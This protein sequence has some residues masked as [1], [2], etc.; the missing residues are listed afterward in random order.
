MWLT[1]DH[2]RLTTVAIALCVSACATAE[3]EMKPGANMPPSLQELKQSSYRGILPDP[4]RLTNGDYEGAPYDEGGAARPMVQ[5]IE[6]V[7]LNGDLDGDGHEEAAVV[8]VEQSSGSG[9]RLYLAIAGRDADGATTNLATMLIGDRVQIISASIN[10]GGVDMRLVRTGPEDACCCPGEIVS[11]RWTMAGGSL[12]LVRDKIEGRLNAAELA[13]SSWRLQSMAR[14]GVNREDSGITVKFED[15]RVSGRSGCNN[16]FGGIE[17]GAGPGELRIG[18]LAGTRMACAPPIMELE[19]TY[20]QAL[21]TSTRFSFLAGT[22]VLSSVDADGQITQLRFV[23]Q[24][25]DAPD[26]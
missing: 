8:L 21:Q 26:P 17:D 10:D 22:L 3:Q 23:R 14:D 25:A 16:Y 24:Q 18:P 6:N 5:L 1:S 11:A 19:S 7:Y 13:G 9:T 2:R 4:V 20:L 12:R 15:Q